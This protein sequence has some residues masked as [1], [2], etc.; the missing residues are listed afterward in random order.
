M[1]HRVRKLT[2]FRC[3]Y[4]SVGSFREFCGRPRSAAEGSAE[5]VETTPNDALQTASNHRSERSA[6]APETTPSD[7]LQPPPKRDSRHASTPPH[8]ALQ[9][10]LTTLRRRRPERRLT[11]LC[12]R[13]RNDAH[14]APQT[15]PKR[16]SRRSP[17][18]PKTT[19][20]TLPGCPRNAAQGGVQTASKWRW[21][22][23]ASP[24]YNVWKISTARVRA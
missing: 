7:A 2:K 8:D 22:G 23:S 20:T 3:S 12:R 18:G 24:S 17:N 19:L 11:T 5:A 1:D 16:H 10:P 9:T 14:D 4:L 13:P 6:G 15:A 21:D